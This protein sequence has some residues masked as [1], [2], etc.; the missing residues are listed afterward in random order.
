MLFMKKA[1]NFL[2]RNNKVG[3]KNEATRNQWV[4]AKLLSLPE[5]LRILDAGAGE[6]QYKKYCTH[7]KYVSQ[8]FA[9]YDGLGDDVGLQTGSWDNSNLDI[10]GD[11]TNIPEPDAS[12]DVILCTEV[13]EHLPNPVLAIQ[14]F[15]RLLKSDGHLIITAPFC[16]L[17]H[18]APYHYSTGFNRYYYEQHLADNNLK[19]LSIEPN[20]NYFEYIAQE[21]RRIED[22]AIVYSKN[23]HPHFFQRIAIWM[24]LN[25]L[26]KM[27]QSDKGSSALL[28]FGCHVH[29]TKI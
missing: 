8:D 25:M 12:F 1:F 17:T 3:T 14:E 18:F 22:V 27:S 21:V 13:F 16:S 24:M 5:G 11:I 7:L 6:Q 26:N 4:E 29:A 19:S 20:G 23:K 9:Q 10:V 15:S 2:T 28:H